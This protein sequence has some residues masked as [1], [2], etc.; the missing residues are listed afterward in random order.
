MIK[1]VVMFVLNFLKKDE[2]FKK[3]S[4]NSKLFN[5]SNINYK[6]IKEI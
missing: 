2:Y 3:K 6:C 5:L 4:K 1:Y